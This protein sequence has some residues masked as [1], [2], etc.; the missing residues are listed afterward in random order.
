MAEDNTEVLDAPDYGKQLDKYQGLQEAGN[1]A[2][3]IGKA[4]Q[5]RKARARADKI[6]SRNEGMDV[7]GLD[8]QSFDNWQDFAPGSA[9]RAMGILRKS[10]R[11]RAQGQDDPGRA[12]N[13]WQINTNN[14]VEGQMQS[15]LIDEIDPSL[16][17]AQERADGFANESAIS[18]GEEQQMRSQIASQVAGLR[19]SSLSR[20]G[21]AMGYG[22]MENSPAAAALAS[23]AGEDAGRT[24][25]SALSEH[26]LKV[27]QLNRDQSRKDTEFATKIAAAR[28]G[29]LHGNAND[30]LSMRGDISSMIDALYSRDVAIDM[31]REAIKEAGEMSM[32]E[33]VG[34]WAGIASDFGSAYSSF[35]GPGGKE[36]S[37]APAAGV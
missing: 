16:Q 8:I 25:V 7:S 30:L 31:Q 18:A 1:L 36:E 21:A 14:A 34:G 27:S 2:E 12:M 35:R 20:I 37:P 9:D 10:A 17:A 4:N 13:H 15:S 32:M 5:A 19:S 23:R 6:L 33:K 3:R 11:Q 24:L 28:Y 22:N 29:L 26:A